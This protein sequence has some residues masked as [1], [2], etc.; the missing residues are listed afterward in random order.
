V[1]L[2]YSSLWKNLC[3]G[4]RR[5][6]V[7][8]RHEPHNEGVVRTHSSMRVSYVCVQSLLRPAGH[9]ATAGTAMGRIL[10]M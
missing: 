10:L 8:T 6:G 7:P 3:G 1:V 2:L 9:V 5:E 4:G